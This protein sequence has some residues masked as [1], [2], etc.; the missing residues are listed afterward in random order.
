ME[1]DFP[2]FHVSSFLF[3]YHRK[4]HPI[5]SKLSSVSTFRSFP[6][7]VSTIIHSKKGNTAIATRPMRHK[8]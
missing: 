6:K 7:C 5:H 4:F 2:S 1:K 3:D 8:E